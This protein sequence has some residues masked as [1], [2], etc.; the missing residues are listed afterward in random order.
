M[1]DSLR[2]KLQTIHE[3]RGDAKE[4][5]GIQEI[6]AKK[7][8]IMRLLKERC[9]ATEQ[10]QEWNPELRYTWRVKITE[11]GTLIAFDDQGN[12]TPITLGDIITDAT[13]GIGYILPGVLPSITRKLYALELAKQQ[14]L[15]LTNEQ[16][17][18]EEL[19]QKEAI[20]PSLEAVAK[21][22]ADSKDILSWDI[23]H[24]A[25]QFIRNYLKKI[26]INR[27]LPIEIIDVD[28]FED[29]FDKID[30]IM[31]LRTQAFT[32]DIESA[33]RPSQDIA[34][35]FTLKDEKQQVL[36]K[37]QIM[38]EA[39]FESG[40]IGDIRIDG[41]ILI[42]LNERYIRRAIGRWKSER[43]SPSSRSPIPGGPERH[44]EGRGQRELLHRLLD[45]AFGDAK[46][47]DILK[48]IGVEPMHY[49]MTKY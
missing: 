5:D 10:N 26:S 28:I 47:E 19:H 42:Y 1:R 31:R 7:Q 20:H 9:H 17:F 49:K 2:E 23:G 30:F 8:D 37:R 35:Q 24:I 40:P 41:A 13:W 29:V 46:V 6:Q 14:L 21:R 12:E 25:E 34:V 16:I 11:D 22:R 38:E 43:L 32:V 3:S 48:N 33:E 27:L 4:Q 45:N 36:K 44:F 15:E 18:L 39:L